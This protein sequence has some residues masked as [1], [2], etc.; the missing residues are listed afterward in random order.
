MVRGVWMNK[1]RCGGAAA[2]ERIDVQ[3]LDWIAALSEANLLHFFVRK[4]VQSCSATD[5]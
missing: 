4:N 3:R 1:K 2:S 5:S